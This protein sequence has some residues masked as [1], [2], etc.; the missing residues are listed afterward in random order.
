MFKINDINTRQE[1]KPDVEIDDEI[2]AQIERCQLAQFEI[3][4]VR[5]NDRYTIVAEIEHLE[6]AQEVKAARVNGVNVVVGQIE[7][8]KIAQTVERVV[9]NRS[10]YEIER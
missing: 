5:V 10:A 3:E 6:I 9:G 8:L 2:V 7:L 1:E 4:Q